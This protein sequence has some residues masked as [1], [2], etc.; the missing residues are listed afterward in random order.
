MCVL[1]YVY[2]RMCVCMDVGGRGARASRVVCPQE[3]F[4]DIPEDKIADALAAILGTRPAVRLRMKARL[5]MA[6]WLWGVRVC[7]R[8]KKPPDA[9]PLQQG[10]GLSLC[11]CVCVYLALRVLVL[12][13]VPVP[14]ARTDVCVWA[15]GSIGRDV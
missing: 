1:V 6:T 2:V 14:R 11:L 12:V 15:G 4:V 8:P 7:R 5:T 3:P 9:H 10:Q 13:S